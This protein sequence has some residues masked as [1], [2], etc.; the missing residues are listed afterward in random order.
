MVAIFYPFSQFYEIDISLPS[1]SEHTNTAPNLFQRGVDYGKHVLLMLLLFC[2]WQELWTPAFAVSL[3]IGTSVCR[4]VFDNYIYIY[5]YIYIYVCMCINMRVY[6]YIYTHTY[7]SNT[8]MH[9]VI[10][11]RS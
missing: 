8:M 7:N 11:S 9:L 3:A 2:G 5:I 4:A 6:I 1:L 10:S